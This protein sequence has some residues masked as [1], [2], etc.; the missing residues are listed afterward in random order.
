MTTM[1]MVLDSARIPSASAPHNKNNNSTRN[2]PRAEA[3]DDFSCGGYETD[4]DSSASED[5]ETDCDFSS[6][7]DERSTA[8]SDGSGDVS[9][10]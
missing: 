4:T 3:C 9:I 8:S 2:M 1:E 7:E 6:P 5:N 10:H